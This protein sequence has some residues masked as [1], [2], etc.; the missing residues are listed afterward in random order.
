MKKV[1]VELLFPDDF[2]PP[3]YFVAPCRKN[4]WENFCGCCPLYAFDD[5]YGNGDCRYY[6][7]QYDLEDGKIPCP[8]KKY[9]TNG[10]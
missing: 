5:E 10:E 2:T 4:H 7:D 6:Y 3:E 9:F 8:I 1:K